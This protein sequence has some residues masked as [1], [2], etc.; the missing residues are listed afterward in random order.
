ME[1]G[2][3][4]VRTSFTPIRM[5]SGQKDP[6][7]L[8]IQV[9]NRGERT[10]CYSVSVKVPFAFGFDRSGLMR[11]HRVRIKNVN[12]GG[13]KEAVFNIYGKFNLQPGFYPFDVI[14]REHADER[15]DKITDQQQFEAKLRVE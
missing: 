3:M 7:A 15:F 4:Y 12:P 5:I 11:E 10:R 8:G 6:V 9:S 14:V 2:E 13:A 1:K